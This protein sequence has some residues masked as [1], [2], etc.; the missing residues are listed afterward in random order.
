MSNTHLNI[1]VE[2]QPTVGLCVLGIVK[3]LSV[4][5]CI[6]VKAVFCF[7]ALYGS[8]VMFLPPCFLQWAR[9][10]AHCTAMIP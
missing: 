2:R 8:D 9:F 10:F 6:I 1:I 7:G 4:F 5:F 3:I